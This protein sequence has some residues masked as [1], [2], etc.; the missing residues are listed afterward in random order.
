MTMTTDELDQALRAEH[1]R[2]VREAAAARAL[3]AATAPQLEA[4]ARC[5]AFRN[6]LA[7]PKGTPPCR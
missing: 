5:I 7:Q 3:I 4:L 2:L 1:G 6:R